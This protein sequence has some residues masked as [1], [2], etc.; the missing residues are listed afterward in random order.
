[1]LTTVE[2]LGRRYLHARGF[3]SLSIPTRAGRVHVLEGKGSGELPPLVFLHGLGASGVSFTQLMA[4]LRPLTSRILVPD[5]PGHGHSDA[6]PTGVEARAVQDGLMDVLDLLVDEP[7]FLI[8]TSLGGMCAARYA[9]ARSQ[10]VKGVAMLAP[11]G[12]PMSERELAD[13]LTVFEIDGHRDALGFV[14]RC[15]ARKPSALMRHALA[16]GI[17]NKFK[18]PTI[19]AFL[20]SATPDDLLSPSELAALSMPVLMLWGEDEAVLPPS[21]FDFYAGHLP[22]HAEVERWAGFGH[23]GFLE[24]S[25][26]V[27]ARLARFARE[28]LRFVRPSASVA[29]QAAA[30]PSVLQITPARANVAA[31]PTPHAS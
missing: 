13:L 19:R 14:D 20:A 6:P 22:R 25:D 4:A 11:G 27:A 28:S 8:G 3:R 30:A 1:M 5:L 16:Y 7:S 12:A 2:R 26:A 21:V 23:V 17:A 10:R 29:G 18:D 9:A 24:D 31:S 15:W